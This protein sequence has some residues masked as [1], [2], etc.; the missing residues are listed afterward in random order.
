M[1]SGLD[2]GGSFWWWWTC[3]WWGRCCHRLCRGGRWLRSRYGSW[4]LGRL[5]VIKLNHLNF[6]R[7][8]DF[9]WLDMEHLH[10]RQT[11]A[12]HAM[13]NNRHSRRQHLVFIRMLKSHHHKPTKEKRCFWV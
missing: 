5:F 6:K 9:G 13:Q 3:L 12:C 10:G 1:G 7:W 4:W 2:S 8:R 11:H